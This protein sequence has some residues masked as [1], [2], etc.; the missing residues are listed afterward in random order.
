MAKGRAEQKEDRMDRME[1]QMKTLSGDVRDE[2]LREFKTIDKP[3]QKMNEDEQQHLI[4]RAIDIA[5]TLVDRAV[6]IVASRGCEFHKVTLGDFQV[7]ADGIK[8]KFTMPGSQDGVTDLFARISTTLILVA[9]DVYQF[10]GQRAEATPDVV[11]N[12]KMP[13]E[14]INPETGEVNAAH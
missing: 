11:G 13:R 12:L 6:D 10:E 7:T 2:I 1:L 5:Y 8:G 9:R 14:Q 4:D 3:W